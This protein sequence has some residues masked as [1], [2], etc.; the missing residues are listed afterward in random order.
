MSFFSG[1]VISNKIYLN[2]GDFLKL[3]SFILSLSLHVTVLLLV[4]RSDIAE[5]VPL[6]AE[7]KT[8]VVSLAEYV[9][10]E[11]KNEVLKAVVPKIEKK[12]KNKRV[13]KV[14]KVKTLQKIP[15]VISKVVKSS[16][17]FTPQRPNVEQ[18]AKE[19]SVTADSSHV[20][21]PSINKMLPTK[22]AHFND[23]GKEELA[24]I[25]LMIEKALCYPA[26]AKKLGIEGVVVVSFSLNTQ[27][28]L[29]DIHIVSSSGS[30]TLDKKALQ[31]VSSL[32]GEY[33]HLEK[34]VD[35]KIPIAFSLKKS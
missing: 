29:E 13:K 18:K 30:S 16:E 1:I 15:P 10:E 17:A 20:T 12:Q 3:K 4:F 2:N 31:T 25:R 34:K 24:K 27:G 7:E 9:Q 26:I 19:D 28:C 23:I 6:H 22:K 14:E 35:L 8:V 5:P 32:D 21:S 33:P 11:P